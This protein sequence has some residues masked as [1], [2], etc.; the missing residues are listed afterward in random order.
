MTDIFGPSEMQCRTRLW[1]FHDVPNHG[2]LICYKSCI[3][4]DIPWQ[5]SCSGTW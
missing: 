2:S 4:L 3:R 5:L 1:P